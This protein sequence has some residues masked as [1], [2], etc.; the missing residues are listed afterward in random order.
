[1]CDFILEITHSKPVVMQ[2]FTPLSS[3]KSL[4]LHLGDPNITKKCKILHIPSLSCVIS[5]LTY[6]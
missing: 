1:M 6:M 2:N 3:L 5:T 4:G